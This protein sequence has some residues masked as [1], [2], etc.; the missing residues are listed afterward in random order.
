MEREVRERLVGGHLNGES[1]LRI[2][3]LIRGPE[4]ERMDAA[5]VREV[6][7]GLDRFVGGAPQEE[8]RKLARG[9]K[10]HKL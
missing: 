6:F 8:F 3:T 5:N 2:K 7:G 1:L 4:R 9:E 10:R